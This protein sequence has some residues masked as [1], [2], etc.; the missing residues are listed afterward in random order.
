MT[1][2][3]DVSEEVSQYEIE[4]LSSEDTWRCMDS[5]TDD[6]IALRKLEEWRSTTQRPARLVAVIRKIVQELPK[7]PENTM[8]AVQEVLPSAQ[9]SDTLQ[10]ILP[11]APETEAIWDIWMEGYSATGQSAPARCVGTFRAV[12]FQKA[13]ETWAQT[14][15][16][17]SLFNADALTYWGCRLYPSEAEA[18]STFG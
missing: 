2:C 15:E 4:V 11:N 8:E 9:D 17:P 5:T 6:L 10:S 16:S 7:K 13:C 14:S 1:I 18:R 3:E 12:S